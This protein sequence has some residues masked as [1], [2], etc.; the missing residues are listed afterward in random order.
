MD[1]T[2]AEQYA[3]YLETIPDIALKTEWDSTDA[4]DEKFL[5]SQEMAK[6][7]RKPSPQQLYYIN[8]LLGM[9]GQFKDACRKSEWN[10]AMRIYNDAVTIG[11]FLEIPTQFMRELLGDD[12]RKTEGM[13]PRRLVDQVYHECAV[14]GN[15]CHECTVCRIPGK[16]GFYEAKSRPG[17]RHTA[18]EENP[19]CKPGENA[20]DGQLCLD[21]TA[22]T[23]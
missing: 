20:R 3:A 4:R 21:L 12:E 15:P 11:L 14:R 2:E 23:G 13:I 16:N 10:R 22:G 7:F 9:P 1:R 18:A 8:K 5:I 19:S 6:R 17:T